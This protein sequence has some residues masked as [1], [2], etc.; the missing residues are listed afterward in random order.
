MTSESNATRTPAAEPNG[1]EPAGLEAPAKEY[2]T[3]DEEE[4]T[5][6]KRRGKAA[7]EQAMD[8]VEQERLT[9]PHPLTEDERAELAVIQAEADR[10]LGPLNAAIGAVF[11]LVERRL[12]LGRGAIGTTHAVA[13]GEVRPLGGPGA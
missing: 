13:D 9:R 1:H 3:G 11:R 12:G 2:G 5:K 7:I 4:A 6:K 10:L 8:A